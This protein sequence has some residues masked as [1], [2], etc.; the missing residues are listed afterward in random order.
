MFDCDDWGRW[1]IEDMH[2]DMLEDLKQAIESGECFDSG[3]H[4]FAKTEYSFRVSR[5]E[6]G[7]TIECHEEMDEGYDLIYDCVTDSEC[8]M[9]T[10]EILDEIEEILSSCLE[11]SYESHQKRKLSAETSFEK[12][13]KEIRQLIIACREELNVSY[14]T[15]LQATLYT[16]YGYS[17]ETDRKIEERALQLSEEE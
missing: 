7:V 10:D 6:N 2:P 5:D 3:W 12:V 14:N 15:C 1:G 17:E 9:L 13:V 4:G 8:E 16:L 11:F